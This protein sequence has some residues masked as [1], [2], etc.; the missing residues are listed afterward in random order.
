MPDKSRFLHRMSSSEIHGDK[1]RGDFCV[2]GR[3]S[4]S[5]P[6]LIIEGFGNVPL[7]LLP[8]MLREMKQKVPKTSTSKARSLEFDSSAVS[9]SN[10]M[11]DMALRVLM[12]QVADSLGLDRSHI[13]YSLDKVVADD[14]G[15]SICSLGLQREA[16]RIGSLEIQLPSIFEGGSHTVSHDGMESV[17]AMGADDSSC[18][19]ESWYLARY[20]NCQHEIQAIS[21]GC[22]LVAVYSLMWT[23]ASPPPGA[24]AMEAVKQLVQ[25]T[26]TWTR[27]AGLCLRGAVPDALGQDGFSSLTDSWDRRQIGLLQAAGAHMAQG[28]EPDQL[29]VHLCTASLFECRQQL[30][31]ASLDLHRR[32]YCPDRSEPS[33][34]ARAILSAFHF[35]EDLLSVDSEE[36]RVGGDDGDPEPLDKHIN[37]QGIDVRRWRPSDPAFAF[38]CGYPENEVLKARPHTQETEGPGGGASG[39]RLAATM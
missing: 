24:P 27:C 34:A 16:N 35:P 11:W 33:Q 38:D 2:A 29:V 26:R 28:R 18:K 17:F 3:Y 22:R 31:P 8:P 20:S 23:G 5:N 12:V 32:I 13:R 30:W 7:P 1:F 21:A 6:G 9:F 10:P 19:Y 39:A 15:D 14:I 25:T 4:V 36:V 37:E